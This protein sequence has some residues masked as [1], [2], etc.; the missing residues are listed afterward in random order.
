[1]P[2]LVSIRRQWISS[3]NESLAAHASTKENLSQF[4]ASFFCWQQKQYY[5]SCEEHHSDITGSFVVI[6]FIFCSCANPILSVSGYQVCVFLVDFSKQGNDVK[7]SELI[8]MNGLR[9]VLWQ[10][11]TATT[12]MLKPHSHIDILRGDELVHRNPRLERIFSL[13]RVDPYRTAN[14]LNLG[15]LEGGACKV[16]L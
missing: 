13:L 11:F 8:R 12:K 7:P 9:S 1:V 15:H 5:Y 14:P 3:T 10:N 6:L 16:T 2:V 4:P